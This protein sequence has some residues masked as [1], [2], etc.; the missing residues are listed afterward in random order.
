MNN[1]L[2]TLATIFAASAMI[3]LEIEIDDSI[4]WGHKIAIASFG[5]GRLALFYKSGQLWEKDKGL[6]KWVTFMSVCLAGV[7]F[8]Y[9]EQIEGISPNGR[10]LYHS[11][12]VLLLF[13][14]W[15]LALSI[16]AEGENL[17]DKVIDLM[18]EKGELEREIK[19]LKEE[20]K[21][22]ENNEEIALKEWNL[23]EGRLGEAH[24]LWKES[25]N[26]LNAA[27]SKM[28]T[29]ETKAKA[30]ERISKIMNNVFAD[31]NTYRV[32][33]EPEM[34]LYSFP[35]STNEIITNDG[36]KYVKP[37]NGKVKVG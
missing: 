30:Y 33:H 6:A 3:W 13:M 14:E 7:V 21:D 10:L 22:S 2:H 35:R 29:L 28:K 4:G 18:G 8:V 27:E 12:N 23:C 20:L 15:T 34:K 31:G 37:I 26:K 36:T 25:E 1:A 5:C 9:A 16:I 11:S 32:F 24:K 17:E 19:R